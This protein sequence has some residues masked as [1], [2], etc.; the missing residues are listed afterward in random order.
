M[1]DDKFTLLTGVQKRGFSTILYG[2]A[3]IGKTTLAAH[4][5]GAVLIDI[6]G[7]A[8]RVDVAKTPTLE[9]WTQVYD[10]MRHF[11]NNDSK[12]VG[13]II[14]DTIDVLETYMHDDICKREGKASIEK[15]PYGAGYK[16]AIDLWRQLIRFAKDQNSRGRNIIMIAHEQIRRFEDPTSDGYDRYNIKINHNSSNILV[17]AADAVLFAHW[18][19]VLKDNDRETMK[20]AVGTGERLLR[21]VESP[22]VVAKNR[23]NLKPIEKMDSS[24]WEKMN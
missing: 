14:F 1:T 23:Y 17:G 9:S 4:A 11:Y 10:W 18:K 6:E 20:K 2:N 3:G 19:T 12:E 8:S 21:C 5:P 13:T 7:G 24:I 22:A 15:F 16:M